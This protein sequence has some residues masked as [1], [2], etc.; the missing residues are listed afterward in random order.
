MTKTNTAKLLANLLETNHFAKIPFTIANF[1]IY[2][3][4]IPLHNEKCYLV[5]RL[6]PRIDR[7]EEKGG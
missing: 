3:I 5:D 7:L 1:S 6:R 2:I 4:S